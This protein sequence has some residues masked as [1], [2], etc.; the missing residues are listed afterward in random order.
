MITCRALGPI[1]ITIEGR[2]APP[3]LF[4]RKNLAL[5][6]YLAR[7]PRQTRARDH[8]VGLLWGDKSQQ[9]AR[10]SLREAIRVLRRALGPDGLRSEHDQ[11]ALAEGTVSLDTDELEYAERA[12]DWE[13]AAALVR[14]EFLEGFSVAEASEFEDWLG[15]ERERW[16]RRGV[17]ALVSHARELADRGRP[18]H[19]SRVALRALAVDPS[20]DV[21]VQAVMRSEALAGNRSRALEHFDRFVSRLEEYGRPPDDETR[22][23]AARIRSSKKWR[24]SSEVPAPET[25]G[26]EL[27]R[28]PLV[29]REKEL[30]LLLEAWHDCV[31]SGHAAVAFVMADPGL[32]KSRLLDELISRVR[33]EGAVVV[34]VRAVEGDRHRAMSGVMGL[35]RG[36]LMDAAGVAGAAPGALQAF[37]AII[38]E[39]RDRFGKQESESLPLGDALT[40][41]VQAASVE[42]PVLLA[43]D[44]AHWCDRESLLAL[45]ASMRTLATARIAV[46]FALSPTADTLELDDLRSR[47]GRDVSGVAITLQPLDERPLRALV[48]WAMPS[49][50]DEQRA[51]LTR[52][53]IADSAGLPLLAVELLHAVSL[54]LDLEGVTE[55]WPQ[56]LRTL[57][58]T[59][60]GDLP[61]AIVAAIRV[62]FHRLSKDAQRVLAAAAVLE[63]RVDA[64]VL[65]RGAGIGGHALLAALDELEWQRWMIA[66]PR[67]YSFVA[68]VVR[69]VIARDMLTDGQRSRILGAVRGVR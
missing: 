66:E 4:W 46:A 50:T 57:D 22:A 19:G 45:M 64:G 24:L 14:G 29:G 59:L 62:G 36:G 54:G 9:A 5:L 35:A 68:R 48:D 21:A 28:G 3:E 52:R 51:R 53:L 23:L 27:R 31:E 67:G 18:Q 1:E 12:G 69:D 15:V 37:A 8:L 20:S 47:I 34:A 17:E 58:Q 44:D 6:V 39:W 61:D 55:A 13:R 11:L 43:V 40:E 56:P 2:S 26:A 60:P 16:R 30:G 7:S 38:A 49:Y 33:L 32:G 41:V 10:H 65:E 42:Q 63:D 25:A